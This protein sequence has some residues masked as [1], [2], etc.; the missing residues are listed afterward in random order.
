MGTILEDGPEG[1]DDEKSLMW[2]STGTN[3]Q[4]SGSFCN[5]NVELMG[6]GLSEIEEEEGLIS[7]SASNFSN[8]SRNF[9]MPEKDFIKHISI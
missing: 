1:D 9:Q 4:Y 8:N 2:A 3:S 5:S 6:N 7:D